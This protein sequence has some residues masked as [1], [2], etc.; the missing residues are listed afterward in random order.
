AARGGGRPDAGAAQRL[1]QPLDLVEL[2]AAPLAA[3]AARGLHRRPDGLDLGGRVVG[4]AV[5]LPGE[6]VDEDREAL[7][8]LVAVEEVRVAGDQLVT[9]TP[10]PGAAE[11]LVD[12]RLPARLW[13]V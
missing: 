4:R 10:G 7:R 9:D 8:V 6:D 1:A 13:P 5:R 12:P 11:V 2:D 3:L